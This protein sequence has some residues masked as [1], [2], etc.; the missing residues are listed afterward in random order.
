MEL[1]SQLQAAGVDLDV[2]VSK[3]LEESGP[4]SFL[5]LGEGSDDEGEGGGR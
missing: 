5:N 3:F 1:Q 2:E 4:F